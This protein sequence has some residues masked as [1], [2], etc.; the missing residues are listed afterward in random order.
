MF[1]AAI[2]KLLRRGRPVHPAVARRVHCETA[3]KGVATRQA[4]ERACVAARTAQLRQE[5]GLDV[6]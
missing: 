4:R 6:R 1:R 2:D 5:L 3:R